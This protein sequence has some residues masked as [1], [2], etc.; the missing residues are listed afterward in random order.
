MYYIYS[1]SRFLYWQI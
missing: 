1:T